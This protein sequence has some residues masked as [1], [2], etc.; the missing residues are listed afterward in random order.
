MKVKIKPNE[1]DV[2]EAIGDEGDDS[3]D[4][5]GDDELEERVARPG[6]PIFDDE[7]AVDGDVVEDEE[8]APEA[9][10]STTAKQG[11]TDYLVHNSNTYAARKTFGNFVYCFPFL[12]PYGRGGYEEERSVRMSEQSWFMRCLRVHGGAFQTHYGF[13]AMGFD[14]ISTSLAYNAQYI[15]MKFSKRAVEFG[16]LNKDTVRL[17]VK[18]QKDIEIYK[19]A[20]VE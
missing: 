8:I 20:L 18:Y 13:I 19:S 17:C 9:P 15:A 5:D 16:L 7:A 10:K 6:N 12:F 3:S 14:F 1:E 2:G 4:D 11:H